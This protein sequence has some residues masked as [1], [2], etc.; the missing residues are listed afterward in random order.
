MARSAGV[1]TLLSA[2]KVTL[3]QLSQS[4]IDAYLLSD[5]PWD[6]AGAYGIQGYAGAFVE[7]IE[8]SYS[9]VVGLPL[10]ET[11][12]LLHENGIELKHG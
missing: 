8:G 2:T 12:T 10:C 4:A 3:T 1:D 5:E 7:R 6:K 9:G 11:R